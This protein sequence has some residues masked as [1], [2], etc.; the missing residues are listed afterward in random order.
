MSMKNLTIIRLL[1]LQFILLLGMSSC[2]KHPDE[3]QYCKNCSIES[4][5]TILIKNKPGWIIYNKDFNKYIIDVIQCKNPT[6]YVPCQFPDYYQPRE[7]DTILFN[8]TIIKNP[9]LTSDSIPISY[10]CVSIDTIAPHK[11]FPDPSTLPQ[12]LIGTWVETNSKVDTIE[13]SSRFKILNGEIWL[14]NCAGYSTFFPYE[15]SND[16][17]HI[18]DPL[19]SVWELAEGMNYYFD[20]D[21]LRL[22]IHIAQFT[23]RLSTNDS[24]L[25]FRKIQ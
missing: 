7:F 25:T 24:I 10:Y 23:F 8:G 17:I 9:Y 15:I 1:F 11:N 5:E 2:V 13:F 12:G 6:L 18:S 22:I 4:L 16:S 21:S 20:F 19:S 14:R 3:I